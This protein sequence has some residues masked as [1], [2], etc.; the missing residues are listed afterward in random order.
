MQVNK[1][2]RQSSEVVLART[3]SYH[4]VSRHQDVS[5]G[6]VGAARA[7]ESCASGRQNVVVVP[8]ALVSG[9]YCSGSAA[10]LAHISLLGRPLCFVMTACAPRY[11][12]AGAASADSPPTHAALDVATKTRATK[13]QITTIARTR[14][15]QIKT[16]ALATN[17]RSTTSNPGPCLFVSMQ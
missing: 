15:P 11:T 5:R 1:S 9:C 10:S 12:W 3:S 2:T 14:K 16:I 8:R 4:S 17:T 6:A 13:P 7:G